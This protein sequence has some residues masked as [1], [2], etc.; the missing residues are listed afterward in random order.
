MRASTCPSL[1]DRARRYPER[2]VYADEWNSFQGTSGPFSNTPLRCG[3]DAN[4]AEE[5][6]VSRVADKAKE[7]IR[8][9]Y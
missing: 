6:Y 7:Q 1:P 5:E 4:N 8:M 2:P 3:V 9:V